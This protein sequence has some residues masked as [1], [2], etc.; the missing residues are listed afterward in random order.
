MLVFIDESGCSGFKLKRG[1]D[2]VFAVAMVIVDDAASAVRVQNA[3]ARAHAASRHAPE[4][5]FSKC[6]EDVRDVFFRTVS[7]EPFQV[8]APIVEKERIY[9]P[10]LRSDT[11]QFY[12]FFVKLLNEHDGYTLRNARVRIDGSGDREF[13]RALS[14]YLRR[15][16]GPGKV[17]DVRMSD[18]KRDP[19]IQLADMCV[20]AI[21]RSYRGDVRAKADRWR[22][23]LQPRISNI[24]EFR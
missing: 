14:S 12:S 5:K 7:S 23:M 13:K 1:S 4:F 20:G 16:L 9:S 18:S 6:S 3:V 15:E 8:R 2:A 21:A 17:A 22:L 19:L 11:K 24:W 10:H